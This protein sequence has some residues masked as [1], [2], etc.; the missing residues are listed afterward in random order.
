MHLDTSNIRYTML[1]IV[2][3]IVG[4]IVHGQSDTRLSRKDELKAL[5]V[6]YNYERALRMGLHTTGFIFGYMSGKAINYRKT[7][8][9]FI[10][11]SRIKHKLEYRPANQFSTQV[12]TRP[13]TYGKQ[14]SLFVLKGGIGRKQL[15]T[16]KMKRRGIALGWSYEIGPELGILKP[17][18]LYLREADNSFEE[19]AERYTEENAD[20]F[21]D[22]DFISG[23]AGF[24]KGLEHT[25]FSLGLYAAVGLQF[26]W[27][28]YD[29]LVRN[30]NVGIQIDAY[31]KRMPIMVL[32]QN[33]FAFI[34]LYVTLQFGKRR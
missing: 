24:W 4:T 28:A 23:S 16:N 13:F 2:F 19:N 18:Y 31:A 26:S 15:W 1:I 33:N 7:K 32:E 29:R 6:V 14:N 9:T 30:I 22:I 34:N 12:I 10:D 5:G 3:S 17:Y 21:L 11:F 20:R 25:K 27:G 8:Y